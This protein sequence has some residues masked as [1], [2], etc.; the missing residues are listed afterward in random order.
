MVE[1]KLILAKVK[2]GVDANSVAKKQNKIRWMER[3]LAAWVLVVILNKTATIGLKEKIVFE[4]RLD[5]GGS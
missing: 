4:E 1:G 2:D 5:G 3:E